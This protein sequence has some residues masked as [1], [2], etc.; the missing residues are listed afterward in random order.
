MK[1]SLYVFPFYRPS[2]S[3]SVHDPLI[4][5]IKA[6]KLNHMEKMTRLNNSIIMADAKHD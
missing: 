4:G 1:S 5:M 6:L 2:R 3:K